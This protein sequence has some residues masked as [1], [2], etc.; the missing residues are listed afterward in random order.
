MA[1]QRNHN[2]FVYGLHSRIDL[3]AHARLDLYV[4]TDAEFG[5]LLGFQIDHNAEAVLLVHSFERNLEHVLTVYDEDVNVRGHAGEEFLRGA[6]NLDLDLE[7]HHVVAAAAAWRDLSHAALEL[8]TGVGA[9]G[10]LRPM[11]L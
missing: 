7:T 4:I 1:A 3:L 10:Y 5:A 11:A 2:R 6:L 9:H 8:P